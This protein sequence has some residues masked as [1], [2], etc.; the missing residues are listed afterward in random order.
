MKGPIAIPFIHRMAMAA[1]L[2]FT[3]AGGANAADNAVTPGILVTERP[4]L[5]SLGFDWKITGDDNR[6]A[7]VAV[8]YRKVGEGKWRDGL[9]LF[10]MGPLPILSEQQFGELE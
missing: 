9:P 3:L 6:N 5:L 7:S 4:T 8:T 10:R 1:S 2:L